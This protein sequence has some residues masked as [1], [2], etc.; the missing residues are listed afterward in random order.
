MQQVE[1]VYN[2]NLNILTDKIGEGLGVNG[3]NIPQKDIGMWTKILSYFSSSQNP[4]I[5]SLYRLWT[6]AKDTARLAFEE[7]LKKISTMNEAVINYT[8]NNGIAAK[9][10]YK[11]MLKRDKYGNLILIDKYSKEARDKIAKAKEDK[12]SLGCAGGCSRD[13]LR[14]C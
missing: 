10:T 8:K 4:H 14:A 5:Q 12:D 1:K 6:G 11:F 7:D 3:I 9:D 13:Y 2:D